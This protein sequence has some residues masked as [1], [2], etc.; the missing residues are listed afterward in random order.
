MPRSEFI[1]FGDNW[2]DPLDDIQEVKLIA[3]HKADGTTAPNTA[4][5]VI[6]GMI[7][8]YDAPRS[9]TVEFP[10]RPEAAAYIDGFVERLNAARKAEAATTM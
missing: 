4:M 8:K 10:T 1:K 5:L 9:Y 6:R 2:I 3:L 7:G